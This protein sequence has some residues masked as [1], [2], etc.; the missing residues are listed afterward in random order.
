MVGL[1]QPSLNR[2][3]LDERTVP[4]RRRYR[5]TVASTQFWNGQRR[6]IGWDEAPSAIRMRFFLFFCGA[7]SMRLYET[8]RLAPRT[9][10]PQTPPRKTSFALRQPSFAWGG[11]VPPRMPAAARRFSHLS[12]LRA[13]RKNIQ[14][15]R[16]RALS[17]RP[18]RRRFPAVFRAGLRPARLP[19]P[20]P[21]SPLRPP[22]PGSNHDRSPP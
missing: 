14:V 17:S 22:K 4:P 3:L 1:R 9:T 18:G 11:P 8:R 20:Q 15:H 6:S 16:P 2:R 21:G 10:L 19:L 7:F 12:W 5:S 13:P